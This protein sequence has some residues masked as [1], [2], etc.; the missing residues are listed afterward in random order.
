MKKIRKRSQD[1]GDTNK[2][3]PSQLKN[4]TP[5]S[6]RTRKDVLRSED[7]SSSSA[8]TLSSCIVPLKT[9]RKAKEVFQF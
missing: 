4:L 2:N 8:A 9:K 7:D 5:K 1:S 6:V 3:L